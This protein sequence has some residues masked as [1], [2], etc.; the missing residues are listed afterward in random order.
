MQQFN[1]SLAEFEKEILRS[2]QQ[3]KVVIDLAKESVGLEFT[4]EDIG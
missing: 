3:L 4:S 1:Q 2:K